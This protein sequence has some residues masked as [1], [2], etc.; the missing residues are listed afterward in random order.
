MPVA[1]V[2]LHVWWKKGWVKS[3][4]GII[5]AGGGRGGDILGAKPVPV[6]LSPPQ[7]P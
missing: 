4:D 2:T 5:L 1:Q 3:I 7:I 6:A